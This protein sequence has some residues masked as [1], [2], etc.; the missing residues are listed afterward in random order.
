MPAKKQTKKKQ[1]VKDGKGAKKPKRIYQKRS[2]TGKP[3]P[4]KDSDKTQ[5]KLPATM[6]NDTT[7]K[8]QEA[9]EGSPSKVGLRSDTEVHRVTKK[10]K[11][12]E[13]PPGAKVLF[14]TSATQ[15]EMAVDMV[16]RR[17]VKITAK[18]FI[19]EDLWPQ[20]EGMEGAFGSRARSFYSSI[21]GVNFAQ[22][23]RNEKTE[24][25]I[26][27]VVKRIITRGTDTDSITMILNIQ[28]SSAQ[29]LDILGQGSSHRLFRCIYNMSST[30]HV[31]QGDPKL[32]KLYPLH[33]T[34]STPPPTK[35]LSLPQ[36]TVGILEQSPAA[37]RQKP[38]AFGPPVYDYSTSG[39]KLVSND[40]NAASYR[41]AARST[42][43][44]TA[45][46]ETFQVPPANTVNHSR[47]K[48]Y[49]LLQSGNENIS[50]AWKKL[51]P[52]KD[53]TE[54][55]TGM[56][57][58][59]HTTKHATW[60]AF[61]NKVFTKDRDPAIEKLKCN[62]RMFFIRLSRT[63]VDFFKE[64]NYTTGQL[65]DAVVTY[66][67][68]LANQRIGSDWK[69]TSPKSLPPKKPQPTPK[70]TTFPSTPKAKAG[71]GT[72]STV[73]VFD[74]SEAVTTTTPGGAFIYHEQLKTEQEID[75]LDVTTRA[76]RCQWTY[77]TIRTRPVVSADEQ[78][79]DD[80]IIPDINNALE[81]LMEVDPT[82]VVY[83]YPSLKR[84]VSDTFLA[85]T[86]D[87][88]KERDGKDQFSGKDGLR[89]YADN[90]WS[91]KLGKSSWVKMLLGHN[92]L[93][94]AIN[95]DE[96]TQ[97]CESA[98]FKIFEANVQAC[99]TS[100]AGWLVGPHISTFD[101]KDFEHRMR[102]HPRFKPYPLG[103]RY[104]IPRVFPL[105][106]VDVSTFAFQDKVVVVETSGSPSIR[107][108]FL[109]QFKAVFNKAGNSDLRP[110]GFC[111]TALE[112]YG[113]RGLSSPPL[114]KAKAIRYAK[115]IH[116]DI[117]H[118]MEVIPITG[119]DDPDFVQNF[120]IDGKQVTLCPRQIL[121]TMKTKVDWDTP[122]FTQINMSRDGLVGICH[123][124]EADE[125]R[126]YVDNLLVLWEAQYGTKVRKWFNF[127][128]VTCAKDTTFDELTNTIIEKA[129]PTDEPVYKRYKLSFAQ[130]NKAIREG[131]DESDF[132]LQ[133]DDEEM[134]TEDA[135]NSTHK[136][137][138][139]LTNMFTPTIPDKS[140]P[141]HET[142]SFGTNATGTTDA[143]KAALAAAK[144][145]EDLK[146]T[147][148]TQ[149]STPLQAAE[150]ASAASRS[151]T[152]S[153]SDEN[154]ITHSI[155]ISTT[156]ASV[157]SETSIINLTNVEDNSHSDSHS[158]NTNDSTTNSLMENPPNDHLPPQ[159]EIPLSGTNTTTNQQD[160]NTE[161]RPVEDEHNG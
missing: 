19:K 134:I 33:A 51:V 60:D 61:F 106:K 140:G 127:D 155:Q 100:I 8:R 141:Q 17:F 68:A 109:K 26:F 25:D 28:A 76:P 101:I 117:Q 63:P 120:T 71:F 135:I 4:K 123:P 84:K 147:Q 44:K 74:Q 142:G 22:G 151:A 159:E 50:P 119:I 5:T 6:R 42:G 78:A 98:G 161:Q 59:L 77:V 41:Q 20:E 45:G 125:A 145:L 112:W 24:D 23:D 66:A 18:P 99:T 34:V 57:W 75:P 62:A 73:R 40:P 133:E 160:L 43:H 144:A 37:Y 72:T 94:E 56:S 55:R 30:H 150:I 15:Q 10:K 2:N 54:S 47:A 79:F 3:K 154:S 53:G 31:L 48:L 81:Q 97:H 143:T 9:P 80:T 90:V 107:T 86:I 152:K 38:F 137:E 105:E 103:L 14:G 12:Q 158:I 85:Y 149:R 91:P 82:L 124:N 139:D 32:S 126:L 13:S 89:P 116:A 29:V 83:P 88:V 16:F 131:A 110:A 114:K 121:I 35:P 93:W 129:E 128:A 146:D 118:Q 122:I 69:F 95:N 96:V 130:R 156:T 157:E 111:F 52:T 21:M 115:R 64:W 1:V 70:N 46:F 87:N 27:P 49:S 67:W 102:N 138:F 153:T 104:Q 132:A 92:Q 39:G 7:N 58:K 65:G 108:E 11:S 36:K 148:D 113:T 136:Y